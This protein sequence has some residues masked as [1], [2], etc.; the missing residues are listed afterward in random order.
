MNHS[1][2]SHWIEVAHS[3]GEEFAG[4]AEAHDEDDAFVSE[5]YAALKE[6]RVFSAAIPEEL[7]GGGASHREVCRHAA[8]PRPI[9]RFHSAG[10]VDASASHR[11]HD[12][13]VP[14][15]PGRRGHAEK[16]RRKAARA[17][18]HRRRRLA[19]VQRFDDQDRRRLPG[20]RAQ[21]LCQSVRGRGHAGHECAVPGRG[22]A[23]SGAD[24][25]GR[26]HGIERLARAGHERYRFSYRQTG[27]RL[28][29]RCRHRLEAA[30]RRFI[31]RFGMSS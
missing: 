11:R 9:L 26:S 29:T 28:R 6:R 4:R 12:L 14:A 5:N 18:Q 8:H 3:L 25:C 22:A 23:F 16:R 27:K 7:G 21:T 1:K 31:T 15:R 17:R 20:Q 24:E 13:E 10:A 30:A 2:A 19:G